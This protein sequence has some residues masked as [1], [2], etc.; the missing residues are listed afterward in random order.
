MTYVTFP[1]HV[2]C[3]SGNKYVSQ[4]TWA[5]GAS[6]PTRRVRRVHTSIH[7]SE[8]NR[9]EPFAS[10]A[11]TSWCGLSVPDE[12]DAVDQFRPTSGSSVQR[13]TQ[14]ITNR[15]STEAGF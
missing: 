5:D 3:I 10:T 6:L 13:S 8:P 1:G 12:P 14:Q 4:Q 7:T 2:N 11:N 9:R 15:R